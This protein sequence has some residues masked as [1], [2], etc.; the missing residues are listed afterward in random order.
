MDMSR[1][2]RICALSVAAV[3]P[4]T[5][6]SRAPLSSD[7]LKKLRVASTFAFR[8]R[9]D[10]LRASTIPEIPGNAHTIVVSNLHPVQC[11]QGVGQIL[12]LP[13]TIYVSDTTGLRPGQLW[14][15]FG[16]AWVVG[17]HVGVREIARVPAAY[18]DSLLRAE[19][20]GP[21]GPRALIKRH[22]QDTVA[23]VI[24]RLALDSIRGILAPMSMRDLLAIRIV[25]PLVITSRLF[26]PFFPRSDT[27]HV[28]ISGYLAMHHPP[29]R[30]PD[31]NQHLLFLV[32]STFGQP[33]A[34]LLGGPRAYFMIESAFDVRP[35]ADSA[36]VAS[37]ATELD[38]RN[39]PT[40]SDEFVPPCGERAK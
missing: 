2:L 31:A 19:F 7:S 13:T 29:L 1:W 27:V 17:S 26:T 20:I 15:F 23:A 25:R 16:G 18:G 9:I 36:L 39:L 8:A 5:A 38:G 11:P 6:Q 21:D 4:L 37:V 24:G 10:S 28:E 35:V 40:R 30:V 33:S 22:L 12:N 34:P 3:T 32:H 14:G